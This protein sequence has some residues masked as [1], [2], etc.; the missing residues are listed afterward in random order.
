MSASSPMLPGSQTKNILCVIAGRAAKPLYQLSHIKYFLQS[1]P[2]GNF[3]HVT[4]NVVR[5][6]RGQEEHWSGSFFRRAGSPQWDQHRT[7]LAH[8]LRHAKRNLL[9]FAYRLLS[10]LFRGSQTR[11]DKAV[12]DAVYLDIV[13]SPFLR[14]RLRNADDARF[15]RRVVDLPR[16]A[17]H[18]GNR[19]DVDDFA[20][21]GLPASCL[22][23][24]SHITNIVREFA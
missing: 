8:L 23:L 3:E 21:F 16:I 22:L 10:L 13:A 2:S 6:R 5:Q 9:T 24:L 18:T 20:R 4:R 7:K 1:A 12:T 17:I 15:A 19:G 14:Q 11:I